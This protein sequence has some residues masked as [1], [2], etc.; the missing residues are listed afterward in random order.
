[1]IFRLLIAAALVFLVLFLIRTLRGPAV[2]TMELPPEGGRTEEDIHWLLSRD[3][4]I[5]AIKV[6]REMH[7]VGLREAKEAVDRMAKEYRSREL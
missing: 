6:Y 4:K 5:E 2:R 1:M 3:R 7:G